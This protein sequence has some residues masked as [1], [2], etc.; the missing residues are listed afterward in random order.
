MPATYSPIA[1]PA[2]E[3]STSSPMCPMAT[4]TTPA[5]AR[6]TSTR[7]ATRA[8]NA[9]HAAPAATPAHATASAT[10]MT[11]VR[12]ARSASADMGSTVRPTRPV[13]T[14]TVRL[15]AVGPTPNAAPSEGSSAWVE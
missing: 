12:P 8:Q 4:A 9:V 13:V 6:P 10:V 11:R 14:D 1:R 15:A 5:R 7:V 2:A 3:G